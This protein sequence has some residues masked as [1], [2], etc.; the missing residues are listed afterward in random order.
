MIMRI[1]KVLWHYQYTMSL[2]YIILSQP[3]LHSQYFL[4]ALCASKETSF[5]KVK[6]SLF[7]FYFFLLASSN[8]LHLITSWYYIQ[9][10]TVQSNL[11]MY[12]GTKSWISKKGNLWPIFYTSSPFLFFSFFLSLLRNNSLAFFFF[13]WII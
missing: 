10:P 8:D 12:C 4:S 1:W 7:L 13:T 9:M 11:E 2:K 3:I 6:R 5:Y